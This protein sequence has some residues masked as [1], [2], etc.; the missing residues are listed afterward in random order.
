M[1]QSN[2]DADVELPTTRSSLITEHNGNRVTRL[3]KL[4][5]QNLHSAQQKTLL[6]KR[7][8]YHT[9]RARITAGDVP[10]TGHRYPRHCCG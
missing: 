9:T 6:D 8:L 1:A 3:T 7:S 5:Q 2:G 4:R 10:G